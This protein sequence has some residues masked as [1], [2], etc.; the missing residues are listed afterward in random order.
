MDKRLAAFE[1]RAFLFA[2]AIFITVIYS[3]L[4]AHELS[5]LA[6]FNPALGIGAGLMIVY[7]RR[8]LFSLVIGFFLGSS[9]LHAVFTEAAPGLGMAMVVLST[10]IF[11]G[12]LLVVDYTLEKIGLKSFDKTELSRANVSIFFLAVV[13]ALVGGFIRYGGYMW[14][15]P[16]TLPEQYAFLFASIGDFFGLAILAP[17]VEL[18]FVSER[19]TLDYGLKTRLALY[20]LFYAL[21]TASVLGIAYVDA[22]LVLTRNLYLFILFFLAAAFLFSCR[23][24]AVLVLATL[25]LLRLQYVSLEN[26]E[27]FLF[28]T[29]TLLAFVYISTI[30]A[31]LLKRFKDLRF[32]KTLE[33]KETTESL[34]NMLEYLRGF[35]AL[36]K[37]ILTQSRSRDAFARRT[38]EIATLLFDADHIFS[39]FDDEGVLTMV[40]AK[41]Y[42][43]KRI[44]FL[45]DL[46]DA[47]RIRN[48]D[49][50]FHSDVR[51]D[52]RNRYSEAFVRDK[53]KHYE[54][55]TRAYMVFTFTPKTYYVVGLDYADRDLDDT[56]MRRMS[57]FT[58][59]LN[60]L[61]RKNYV[62]SYALELKDDT[63]LT[64]VRAL[65]LYD[66][67][68]KGHSE[69]VAHLSEKVA[70]YLGLSAEVRKNIYWAGLLH[71]VGKL[72]VPYNIL[73]KKDKL[74]D[75]EYRTIQ[76][77]VQHGY[78]ILIGFEGLKVIATMVNHH[79]EWWNGKGYPQGLK[80]HDISIGGQI[81]GVAD[82]VATMATD[83]PYQ[84][85]RSKEEIKRE[86][87]RYKGTQFS[88]TIVDA[89]V[90]I[91]DRDPEFSTL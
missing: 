25:T 21:L 51:K 24:I 33:L 60:K 81:L 9:F 48:E 43:I 50:I 14:I 65:D 87:R 90:H 69:D 29:I 53:F 88:P 27:E 82:A 26:V 17:I 66:R 67:Y 1:W 28:T 59:I 20:A 63:I 91:L 5:P 31:I 62:T 57:D 41:N 83:R 64:F 58:K 6:L 3:S 10:T 76:K 72:G 79:H 40:N 77:H 16:E 11:A 22:P 38:F 80:E 52:L 4:F 74:T 19:K 15:H 61:F 7:E 8:I 37:D 46:H 71:D 54:T 2:V 12:Q 56:E 70:E 13:V 18:C 73:N 47:E 89:V 55:F 42:P 85:R 36:S 39:Y 30:T 32:A 44:P 23:F 35:L 84:K 86:L 75:D 49:T 78:D 34:D 45:Y 68:T